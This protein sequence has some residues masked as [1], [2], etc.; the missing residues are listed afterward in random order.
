M[1]PMYLVVR[2]SVDKQDKIME[3]FRKKRHAK[4]RV[5]ELH[6]RKCPFSLEYYEVEKK[7]LTI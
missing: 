3:S 7:V 4:K 6:K 2:K 1:T 5:R